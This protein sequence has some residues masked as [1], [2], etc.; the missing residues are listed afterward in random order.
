MKPTK[1]SPIKLVTKSKRE[2]E[3]RKSMGMYADELAEREA[4]KVLKR[5]LY[6]DETEDHEPEDNRSVKVER[7]FGSPPKKR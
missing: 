7:A 6:S 1:Q 3:Q 4:P 2:F 5:M